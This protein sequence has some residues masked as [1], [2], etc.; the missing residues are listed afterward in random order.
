MRS[1]APNDER[2][3]VSYRRI[4]ERFRETHGVLSFMAM[5]LWARA[6]LQFV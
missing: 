4:H 6:V 3:Q 5:K 2:L 1:L